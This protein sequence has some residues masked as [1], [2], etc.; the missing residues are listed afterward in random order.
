VSPIWWG[1]DRTGA[2]ESNVEFNAALTSIS[3][4]GGTL[5]VPAG[6]Y[7][8]DTAAT[9]L[10]WYSNINMVGD[11]KY[12][13]ILQ[14]R[15]LIRGTSVDNVLIKDIQW[16]ESGDNVL[17]DTC[18]NW[19]FESLIFDQ[20]VT[21]TSP[22]AIRFGDST[23]IRVLNS[24]FY[25]ASYAVNIAQNTVENTD[26][27][28]RG[29]RFYGNVFAAAN[30][31]AGV[32]IVAGVRVSII[33]N[34]F[35]YSAAGIDGYG[36]YQ[37]DNTTEPSS[38]IKII[39][40]TFK[41]SE[42]SDIRIKRCERV[43]I[44]DNISTGTTAFVYLDGA[45]VLNDITGTDYLRDVVITGNTKS[46]GFGVRAPNK[47]SNVTISN[48]VFREGI[49]GIWILA[50]AAL[51]DA[52]GYVITD[53]II[54]TMT[55]GGILLYYAQH[56]TIK[57]NFIFDVNTDNNASGAGADNAAI[58]LN[59]L[60]DNVKIVDNYAENI[61]GSSGAADYFL[62]VSAFANH[63]NL[64]VKGN[65]AANMDTA[66]H[67]NFGAYEL[68]I[69][70]G[71]VTA[72]RAGWFNIDTESDA[73]TDDLDTITATYLTPG[74][75]LYFNPANSGRDVTFKDGTGNLHLGGDIS[76]ATSTDTITLMWVGTVFVR[77][78][79]ATN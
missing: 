50:D 71:V 45:N 57:N 30:Y 24:D 31:P 46:G 79:N 36:I 60:T 18:D 52:T 62:N 28:I 2:T 26:I 61:S 42:S 4:N 14:N 47:S 49:R 64:V 35:E 70:G 66:F 75:I 22:D 33:D 77:L 67:R 15:F 73:A 17:L 54:H 29:N 8:D 78:S 13:T 20:D 59:T 1:A 40:N 41:D 51:G 25:D 39:G 19:T 34:Y 74:D 6:T 10:T 43:T 65:E 12:Q 68:T 3:V 16:S 58:S 56:A 21:A 32:F 48:N 27:V 63:T 37:G 44:A 7:D 11:G 53:N 72:P 69:S 5:Y 55:D 76:F 38:D 23:N 9:T